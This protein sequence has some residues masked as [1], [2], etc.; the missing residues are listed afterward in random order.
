MRGAEA[1]LA[2]ALDIERRAALCPDAERADLLAMAHSWRNMAQQALWW[3]AH[4]GAPR[5]SE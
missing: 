4:D 3:D 5:S 1:C 2:K